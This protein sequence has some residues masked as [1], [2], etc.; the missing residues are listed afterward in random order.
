MGIKGSQAVQV[1][2]GDM[3]P[4]GKSTQLIGRKKAMLPLDCPELFD[5]H[6]DKPIPQPQGSIGLEGWMTLVEQF[7]LCQADSLKGAAHFSQ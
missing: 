3:G 7:R 5:N 6:S 2:Q 1:I 4:L